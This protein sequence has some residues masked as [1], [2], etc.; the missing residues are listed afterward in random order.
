MGALNRMRL[1]TQLMRHE[2]VRTKPYEDTEGILTIGVG[3]NL[4]DKGLSESE[5][6]MLLDNDINDALIECTR[7]IPA[8]H[9]MNGVRKQVLVN[10]MFNLG[11]PR[12]MNFVKLMAAVKIGD[13]ETAAAEMLDSKWARQVG[14][15]ALELSRMMRN[16]VQDG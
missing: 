8:W 6:N 13:Y 5:V 11:A 12:L 7:L 14:D 15:R 2:G 16:G 1:K 4:E 9:R 10:M 3:R